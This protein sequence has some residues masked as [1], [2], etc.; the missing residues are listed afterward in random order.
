MLT[1]I[2]HLLHSDERGFAMAIVMGVLMVLSV[3]AATVFAGSLQI[4]QDTANERAGKQAYAGSLNGLRSAMYWLNASPPADAACP[5][6]P[7]LA[8][9]Q[10]PNAT[11]GLCGPYESDDISGV[12]GATTQPLV[13]QR[14]T[15]WI[16]PLLNS[17]TDTCTGKPPVLLGSRPGVTVRD[18]CITA[19][20]QSLAGTAVT[21][22]MRVQA[23]VSATNALFPVPG[24]FGASCLSVGVSAN[25]GD[26]GCDHGQGASNSDYY[27][28]IGSN[29]TIDAQMKNWNSDP[30]TNSVTPAALYLGE[31][32]PGSDTV[33]TYSIKVQGVP[34]GTPTPTGCGNGLTFCNASLPPLPYNTSAS[35]PYQNP[36]HEFGRWF[37]P[38]RMGTLF[39]QPPPMVLAGHTLPMGCA[40]TDV[41]VCNNNS[42]ITSASGTPTGCAT[43][44]SSRVLTLASS[45]ILRIPD[46]TYDFCDM[47]LNRSAAVLPAD[48]TASGEVRI[49][50]DNK[51]R[52]VGGSAACASTTSGSLVFSGNGNNIPRW[53]TNNTSTNVTPA[54][55][56][57]AFMGDPWTSLAGQL[58][59]YG[60]GDP[61]DATTNYPANVGSSLDIPG[62]IFN[63]VVIATNSTVNLT[64]TNA[65]VNGA[66]AGGAVNIS[67][68]VGFKW[69][70]TVDRAHLSQAGN[71]FYR[72]AF[73]TCT[74]KG[75]RFASTAS[76]P[77]Y[78]TYPSDGC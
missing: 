74:A 15:Y 28:T 52:T 60:A 22:T 61:S 39:A 49:F 17:S 31:P 48:G 38:F 45:C 23:R 68:N 66:I 1:R 43:L 33:A 18:R 70:P 63:G 72:T 35:G 65:C 27:G 14:F 32:S 7:G 77:A 6:L 50:I 5:P 24:I 67:P 26:T 62:V 37:Q 10:A 46:G 44:D 42:L 30:S 47:T 40:T 58:Y 21:S 36:V 2:R 13:N 55:C 78:P 3:I 19:V 29:G 57:S 34:A 9:A 56:L 51:G 69:D 71:T 4:K 75:F 59:V 76:A 16:T 64:A 8:T 53:M 73:S 54:G 25:P 20:G 41:S 11:S 12:T